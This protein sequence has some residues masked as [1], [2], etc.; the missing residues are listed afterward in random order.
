MG[1]FDKKNCD[2]C[3]EKIGLLGNRKLEDGNL[4][5]DCAA[6]LSPWFT[7]RRHS[8]LADIRAQLADRE[9]N[10]A[11]VKAF[12]FT[13][14]L[15]DGQQALFV[16]E[17]ARTFTVC[18][19]SD[20]RGK[21][22]DILPLSSITHC[23]YDR[24]EHRSERKRKD[25]QGSLVSYDPP[26]YDYSYDYYILIDVEHPYIDTM[27]FKVNASTLKEATGLFQDS[28]SNQLWKTE[29]QCRDIVSF[30]LGQPVQQPYYEPAQAPAP[31]TPAE[32]PAAPAEESWVC[33]ACTGVNL[34]GKFCEYCGTPRP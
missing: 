23:K 2:I 1:L 31:E 6:K 21:N 9:E 33:P 25:E 22:P 18:Y 4:C 8:A 17:A 5:K 24:D 12:Q 32:A 34:S 29:N 30:V 11:R 28:L 19:E 14:K 7:G 27:K 26:V 15:G 20:L 3:G 10:L 13:R 16:D